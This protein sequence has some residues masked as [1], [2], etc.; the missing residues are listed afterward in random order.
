[1]NKDLLS[2]QGIFIPD[3]LS[4]GKNPKEQNHQKLPVMAFDPDKK[5]NFFIAHNLSDSGK[6]EIAIAKWKEEF[7]SAARESTHPRWIVSSEHMHSRLSMVEEVNRLKSLISPSFSEIEVVLY[8]RK[9]IN[10]AASL[11]STLIKGGSRISDFP[12]PDHWS[13]VKNCNHMETIARWQEVFGDVVKVRLFQKS[14]FQDGDLIKDFCHA[15]DIQDDASFEFPAIKNETLS[16][17]AIRLLSKLN[18]EIPMQK[19]KKLNPLRGNLNR[20]I[21]KNFSNFPKYLPTKEMT[22]A[23]AVYYQESD[24][25]VRARF[26][27]ERKSLFD[28]EKGPADQKAVT[29]VEPGMT[30]RALLGMIKDI[31]VQKNRTILDLRK[32]GPNW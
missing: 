6:R 27:P 12:L 5:D 15:C 14:S 9:P 10:A 13:V 11:W 22:E 32:N 26:F 25:W 8:I 19:E 18:S 29:P 30:E 31:W 1:M 21:I 7:L 3:F 28:D 4:S 24:E 16:G 2:K 20:F 23:Y 17:E